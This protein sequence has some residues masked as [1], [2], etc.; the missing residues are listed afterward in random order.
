MFYAGVACV[1]LG[2]CV[3]K[4]NE[5]LTTEE[6]VS[7]VGQSDVN[8]SESQKNV[9][10][11]AMGSPDHSTLV[12]AVKAAD[13]VNALSNA[14]PFTVFAPMNEAFDKLPDGTVENLLKSE[15]KEQL[16]DILQYHVAVGVYKLE[17]LRDGQTLGMVNRSSIKFKVTNGKVSINGVNVLA[18]VPA[19]NGIVHIID[20]VLTPQ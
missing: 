7:T 20:G 11:I 6:E 8:D 1:M 19:S 15:Q 2:A 9:V 18:S 5:Q 12:L 17:S 14:G 13:L 16:Q 3:Q 4:T 10:Q